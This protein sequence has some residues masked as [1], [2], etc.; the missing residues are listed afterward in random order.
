M[1]GTKIFN[2]NE[3]PEGEIFLNP[4]ESKIL[5]LEAIPDNKIQK[6]SSGLSMAATTRSGSRRPIGGM[7]E[8]AG[9]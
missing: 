5:N 4:G 6:G 2:K 1:A 9:I 7:P 3:F 8:W